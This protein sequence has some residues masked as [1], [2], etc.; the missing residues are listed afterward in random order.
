MTKYKITRNSVMKD[1]S[2][3]KTK[4]GTYICPGW[5]P[6][7]SGT[8]RN[9]VE[10]LNDIIIENKEVVSDLKTEPSKSLKFKVKSSNGKSEYDVSYMNG[11]WGCNCPA[12]TFRR[13]HCK[14]IK[15]LDIN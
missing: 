2:I 4:S 8:T 6:V 9:D 1:F 11:V 13:G 7:D 10:F 3:V 14:H 5:V 15:S 12:S